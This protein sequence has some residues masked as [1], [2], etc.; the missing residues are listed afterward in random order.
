[1]NT[2][3]CQSKTEIIIIIIVRQYKVTIN[4]MTCTAVLLLFDIGL[5]VA[6]KVRL[7]KS[8]YTGLGCT[9]A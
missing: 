7:Q 4:Y 3:V 1:M 6:G 5:E 9:V 8:E 2:H